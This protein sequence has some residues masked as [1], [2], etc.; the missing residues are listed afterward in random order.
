MLFSKAVQ[1]KNLYQMKKTSN[2]MVPPA[3]IAIQD[4]AFNKAASFLYLLEWCFRF[5][6]F[7]SSSAKLKFLTLIQ[8]NELG[9]VSFGILE[10][11]DL[12]NA[13]IVLDELGEVSFGKL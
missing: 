7:V 12:W 9:E 11:G 8:G 13:K 4:V 1:S 6:A 2:K 10:M 3:P 5:C